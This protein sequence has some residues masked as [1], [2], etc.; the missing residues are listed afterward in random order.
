[1]RPPG[2]QWW[3]TVPVKKSAIITDANLYLAEP[4]CISAQHATISWLL[5][6]STHPK[7][8]LYILFHHADPRGRSTGITN[9]VMTSSAGGAKGCS[10]HR[11][12]APPAYIGQLITLHQHRAN[13]QYRTWLIKSSRL[14]V[15][16][17]NSGNTW[18]R[19]Y[20]PSTNRAQCF[21]TSVIVRELVFPSW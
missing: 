12:R 3:Q 1:M 11:F 8:I 15:S 4:G 21:L 10:D 16:S 2:P 14:R 6:T 17:R 5:A 20:H 19:V 13:N 9:P 7:N 18:T